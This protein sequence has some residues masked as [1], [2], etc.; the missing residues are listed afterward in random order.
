MKI[1]I[2][3]EIAQGYEGNQKLLELLTIGAIEAN[4]DSIKFHIS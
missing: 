2:I 3:A 1:E 4:A